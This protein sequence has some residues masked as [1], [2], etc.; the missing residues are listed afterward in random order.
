M[1]SADIAVAKLHSLGVPALRPNDYFAE[2]VKS[3]YHMLK[4]KDRLLYQKRAIERKEEQRMR[5]EQ[6]KF[7]KQ[8]QIAKLKEKL[9]RKK[10]NLEAIKYWKKGFAKTIIILTLFIAHKGEEFDLN[11]LERIEKEMQENKIKDAKQLSKHMKNKK[12]KAKIAESKGKS[13]G[14]VSFEIC[15][16]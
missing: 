10:Q 7:G 14:I 6:Q 9:Q 4:V 12:N 11:K 8:I 5:R 16:Y 1:E 13:K 3:D 15:F 2:M